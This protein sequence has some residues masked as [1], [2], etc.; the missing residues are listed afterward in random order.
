MLGCPGLAASRLVPKCEVSLPPAGKCLDK[1]DSLQ[2]PLVFPR[3]CAMYTVHS[4]HSPI[5]RIVRV[6]ASPKAHSSC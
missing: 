3:A 4:T 6:L 1:A 5:I 2:G